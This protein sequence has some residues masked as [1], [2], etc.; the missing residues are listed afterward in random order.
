M[1]LKAQNEHNF[2]KNELILNQEARIEDI[3]IGEDCWIGSNVTI[4]KGV[5]IC[6]NSVV[7]A[8]SLVSKSI[9]PDEIWAGNPAKFIKKRI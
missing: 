9:P 6:N 7:G 2:K 5:K 8:N 1:I 4:L 3:T